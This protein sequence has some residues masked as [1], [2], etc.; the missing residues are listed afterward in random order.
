MGTDV[1]VDV[2]AWNADGTAA[3]LHTH[4][5]RDGD[6]TDSFSVVA[7]GDSKVTGFQ[8]TGSG[9]QDDKHPH[10]QSV[11]KAACSTAMAALAKAVAAHKLVAVSAAGKAAVKASIVGNPGKTARDPQIW[12]AV[13]ASAGVKIPASPPKDQDFAQADVATTSGKLVVALFTPSMGSP[14]KTHVL[15]F[16]PGKTGFV[17]QKLDEP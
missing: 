11:D 4:T 1:S 6:T 5:N 9:W 2:A 15:L 14:V 3:L 7:V 17:P 8:T 10:A 12:A 16:V 13:E